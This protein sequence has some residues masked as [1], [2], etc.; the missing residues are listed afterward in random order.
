MRSLAQQ[1]FDDVPEVKVQGEMLQLAK[2][3]IDTKRGAFDP[4]TFEDRY[5]AVLAEFVKAKLEGAPVAPPR[6]AREAKVVNLL[7]ALRESAALSEQSDKAAAKKRAA[8]AS[9]DPNSRD[10]PESEL[11]AHVACRLPQE[12]RF[13]GDARAEGAR[14]SKDRQQLRR[15]ETC[16]EATALRSSPG[17]GR[18]SEKLGCDQRPKPRAGRKAACRSRRGPPSRLSQFRRRHSGRPIWRRR[19][20]RMGQGRV[21]SRRRSAQGLCQGPPRFRAARRKA[22]RTLASR[23]HGA[24]AAREARQ[25]ASHQKRRRI[26]ANA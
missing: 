15:P 9:Q 20:D 5:E 23:A 25:L 14:R 8:P 10:T 12:A 19:S 11:T 4:S 6:K 26:C 22:R 21:D 3:I 18:R 16:R 17:D 7:E 2:H 13:W 1:A 24:K